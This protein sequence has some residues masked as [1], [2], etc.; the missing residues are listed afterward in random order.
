MRLSYNKINMAF[1]QKD[2]SS[3]EY[4]LGKELKKKLLDWEKSLVV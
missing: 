2:E 3:R 4:V 1:C